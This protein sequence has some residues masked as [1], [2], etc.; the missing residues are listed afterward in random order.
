MILYVFWHV[1]FLFEKNVERTSMETWYWYLKYLSY[2]PLKFF[3]YIGIL[4]MGN[5]HINVFSDIGK[6]KI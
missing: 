3:K 6:Y 2:K 5:V 1:I 4:I